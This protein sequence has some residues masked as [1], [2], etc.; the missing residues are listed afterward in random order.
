MA[1]NA[2]GGRPVRHQL[3][4]AGGSTARELH[5]T[6]KQRATKTAA[7]TD[8][9]EVLKQGNA[10]GRPATVAAAQGC[11]VCCL[12]SH[13]CMEPP[14]GTPQGRLFVRPSIRHQSLGL[15]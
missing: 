8:A 5:C 11:A 1:R 14:T 4:T 12:P 9:S 13:A 10:N 6:A 7:A 2:R 15:G 3:P